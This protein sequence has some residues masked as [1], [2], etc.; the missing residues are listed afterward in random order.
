MNELKKEPTIPEKIAKL[1]KWAQDYITDAE[2]TRDVAVRELKE[3]NDNQTPS[4]FSIQEYV[5][6]GYVTRYIQ[7]DKMEV[8]AHGVKLRIQL[9]YERDKT[10]KLSWGPAG[11]LAGMDHIAF[12][13]TSFQQAELIAKENMR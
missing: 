10:I 8:E 5:N 3:Y 12:V 4:P 9:G 11:K 2:R 7:T 6:R 1:P 13:P